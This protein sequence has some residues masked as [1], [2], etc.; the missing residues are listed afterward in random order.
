MRTLERRR[1]EP[2]LHG[3]DWDGRDERGAAVSPGVYFLRARL[4]ERTL[5]RP[6]LRIP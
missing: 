6:L 2:G 3:V 1:F 5:A 4:G